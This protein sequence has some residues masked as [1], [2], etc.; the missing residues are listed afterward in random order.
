METCT[1]TIMSP[2]WLIHYQSCLIC[3]PPESNTP[4]HI[5]FVIL[6]HNSYI[7]NFTLLTYI[8]SYVF[9]MFT[10]LMSPSLP[11][12]KNCIAVSSDSL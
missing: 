7:I 8:I 9:S 11:P 6:R 3:G 4:V 10:S 5:I 2:K 1:L 12:K